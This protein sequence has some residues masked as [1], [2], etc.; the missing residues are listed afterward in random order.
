MPKL[1][2]FYLPQFHPTPE[3]DLWWGRGFT[4]WTKV[5]QA[6][7]LFAWHAQPDLPS[8]LGFYDLRLDE[9]RAAQA[10][11]AQ[12]HGLGAFCY[13][14]YWFEGRRLL[15]QPFDAVLAS[16]QPDFPFCLCWANE[17]WTRRWD[18]AEHELLMEQRYSAGDHLEHIRW[19]LRPFQDPR[20]LRVGGKPVFLVYRA[21]RIPDVRA[22]TTLWRE[23]ADRA[24]LPGL[25]LCAVESFAERERVDPRELGF[26]AGVGFHPNATL[27]PRFVGRGAGYGDRL[28]RLVSPEAARYLRTHVV[29]YPDYVQEALRA[30][31]PEHA[32]YPCVMPAW[33]NTPRRGVDGFIWRDATPSAFGRWLELTLRQW[34]DAELVFV[35]AWNEWAEGNH[36]EPGTRWGRAYLEA[37]KTALTTV[38][39]RPPGSG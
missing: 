32:Y 4:E 18:G 17:N 15:S 34:S 29:D 28:R 6:R 13:Y 24:G 19:L 20:Y 35:N 33:D 21:G 31:R 26:D 30:P 22:M 23:E 36:L 7:P 11:L 37:V 38:T 27:I 10:A 5:A 9:T 39:G 3:N 16:A 1:V 8:E 14:H 12:E 2:A 25:H